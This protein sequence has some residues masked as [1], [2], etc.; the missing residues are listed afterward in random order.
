M[1]TLSTVP[2]LSVPERSVARPGRFVM[3]MAWLAATWCVAFATVN[4]VLELTGHFSD[5]PLDRYASGLSVMDWLVVGLKLVGAGLAVL[6]VSRQR[7]IPPG[8]LGM[9]L[10]GAFATLAIYAAGNIVESFGM[11]LGLVDPGRPIR[12]LD[13]G[14]VLFFAV[15]AVPFGVVAISYAR[16]SRLRRLP[17][18][19]GVLGAPALIAS[20]LLVAPVVLTAFGLFPELIGIATKMARSCC[21]GSR[22]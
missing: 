2:R 15:A 8:L 17:V 14:Y 22:S 5:G 20:V 11:L 10:T 12:A 16:R 9:L 13:I 3:T 21:S 6:S 4:V 7:L 1:E 19:L 18:M